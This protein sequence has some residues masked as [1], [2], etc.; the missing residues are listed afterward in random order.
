M[1]YGKRWVIVG[2]MAAVFLISVVM[3]IPRELMHA[4]EQGVI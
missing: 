4:V 3:S 2:W 1:T